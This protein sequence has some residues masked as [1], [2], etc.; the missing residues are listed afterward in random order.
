VS[1]LQRWL[2]FSG[3]S[4]GGEFG[5]GKPF[6]LRDYIGEQI[7]VSVNLSGKTASTPENRTGLM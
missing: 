5:N 4:V 6:H 1:Q 2:C 7:S 3:L